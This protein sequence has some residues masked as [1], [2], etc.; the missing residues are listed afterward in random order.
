MS[1]LIV[2]EIYNAILEGVI[3]ESRDDFNDSAV[4][5]ATLQELKRVWQQRL[6]AM[7]VAHQVWDA[8]VEAPAQ[9]Y[10]SIPLGGESYIYGD[11]VPSVPLDQVAPPSVQI[12]QEEIPHTNGSTAAIRAA[13]NI[14]QVAQD[15]G[16][17]NVDRSIE[18][19]M[20]RGNVGNNEISHN[21]NINNSINNN[22]NNNVNNSMNSNSTN[23]INIDNAGGLELP[24]GGHITQAD[25]AS[26]C[27]NS[28]N[29]TTKSKLI[30]LNNREVSLQINSN[31]TI[32]LCLPHTLSQVDG[33]GGDSDGINSDLDDSEDELNS[34]DEEDDDDGGMIILCLY[35]KVQRVKN[36]W[37]YVLKDGIANVNG[38]DY[39]FTKG[40]GESE[41]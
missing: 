19:I 4:E 13:Q 24:G 31:N 22:M 2:G 26:T 39:I 21:N 37:K 29:T 28:L 35:D 11:Q 30:K 6:S 40:S 27:P 23:N 20:K 8:P 32:Q 9:Q 17:A 10:D 16:I 18:G 34:N 33:D 14:Q 25:G 1:N 12:K 3:S 38:K 41:W 15:S 7:A 36:K 5:E